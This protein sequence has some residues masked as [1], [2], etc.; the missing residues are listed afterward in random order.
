MSISYNITETAQ[1]KKGQGKVKKIIV[2]SHSS[3]TIKLV[4]GFT[5]GVVAT[6]VLTSAGACAPADYA[7]G[8]LTSD[9]TNVSNTETV[10]VGAT[11][12]TSKTYT[13]LT[14][15]TNIVPNE[16]LIGANASESLDNLKAAIN[17]S[18]TPGT[19]YS[20]GTTANPDII[21]YTK[22]AT[23][24]KVA[25]RT[26]GTGGNA[27]TTTETS[28]HLSWGGGTLA[29]GVATTAAT[30]TIDT[31]VYTAVKTL[32]DTIGL[33]VANQVLWVTSEAV[34]LDNVK[35][36]VN[37]TGAPGTDYSA[38][39]PINPTVF[40]TTNTNTQ[41]TFN[42]KLAGTW[43]NSIATTTTLG[44]YS[45]TSTVMASG[46]LL[47][48]KTLVNTLTLSVV[49]TTGER[50]VDFG[51]DGIDFSTGLLAVVGGTADL[52]IL[53]DTQ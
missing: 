6:T 50:I 44:N 29:G 1:I 33:T 27:Y 34:F 15:L 17:A 22:T 43:G 49:A 51:D 36:A 13:F 3:G 41:Q 32:A 11:G 25:F 35:S 40:A 38:S 47:T 23:T 16:V 24:L 45:F 8:T 20:I 18:G 26:L 12:G 10:V 42:A 52:T 7:I 4:D 19:T 39:T 37:Y 28:A 53:V 9:A 21:A 31:M 46:T 48:S 5:N 2:N 14:T 30:F